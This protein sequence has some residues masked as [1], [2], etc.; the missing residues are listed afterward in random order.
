M[1]HYR[2]FI[3]D[4]HRLEIERVKLLIK[5]HPCCCWQEW[6]DLDHYTFKTTLPRDVLRIGVL[7]TLKY[8]EY[9]RDHLVTKKPLT[10]DWLD[11]LVKTTGTRR[12]KYGCYLINE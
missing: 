3:D 4:N 5:R 12:Q 1:A 8:I 10:Y 9:P 6:N 7:S 11:G 2:L